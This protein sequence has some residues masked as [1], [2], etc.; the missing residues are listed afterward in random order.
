MTKCACCGKLVEK[1]DICENCG[2]QDD[3]VQNKNPD[4]TGGANKISLREA[5]KRY[6]KSKNDKEI[7]YQV[8]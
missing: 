5:K 1:F 8:V 3:N 2:W 6:L 4:F 7:K